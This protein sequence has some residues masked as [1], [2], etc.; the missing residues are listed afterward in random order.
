M[1]YIMKGRGK[2]EGSE[3]NK[4]NGEGEKVEEIEWNFPELI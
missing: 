3:K 2:G 4:G 1:F